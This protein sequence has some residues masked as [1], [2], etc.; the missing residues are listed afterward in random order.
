[1]YEVRNFDS[2]YLIPINFSNVKWLKY[3]VMI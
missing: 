1:M 2:F 3:K